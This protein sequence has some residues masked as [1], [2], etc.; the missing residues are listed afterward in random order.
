MADEKNVKELAVST[1]QTY[2]TSSLSFVPRVC[3]KLHP[4]KP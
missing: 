2:G 1:T 4:T 3:V